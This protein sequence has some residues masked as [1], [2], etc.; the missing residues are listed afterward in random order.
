MA[1]LGVIL[2]F[3]SNVNL[4]LICSIDKDSSSCLFP[5][6]TKTISP[7][8]SLLESNISFKVVLINSS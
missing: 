5:S 6:T 3:I 1:S 4:S 7:I 8:I 2:F